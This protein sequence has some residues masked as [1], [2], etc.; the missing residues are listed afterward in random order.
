MDIIEFLEEK[1]DVKTYTHGNNIGTG[2]IGFKCP[3]RGCSDKSNHCGVRLS[4][5]RVSCWKCGGHSIFSLIRAVSGISD[6]KELKKIVIELSKDTKITVNQI[7]EEKPSLIKSYT[8]LPPE[9]TS[10]LPEMHK[11]YLKSRNFHPNI[12]KRKYDIMACGP[13]GKYKF[14]IVIPFYQ[15][16]RLVSFTTRSIFK[17]IRPRYL[18]PRQIEVEISPKKALYNIDNLKEG[19]DALIVEGVT[20][21]WRFGDGAVSLGGIEYTQNQ[22]LLLIRKK[23]RNAFIM[24]DKDEPQTISALVERKAE[25]ICRILSPFVKHTEIVL[26]EISSDLGDFTSKEALDLRRI[27][28]FDR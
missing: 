26:P 10:I 14:R 11:K 7:L 15:N 17:D 12:I 9:A 19:H 28:K 27:L 16:R 13:A 3:F 20:D 2:W 24:F 1:Y 25:E 6:K 4:D 21:V 8:K 5:L 22:I 23:I 18:N